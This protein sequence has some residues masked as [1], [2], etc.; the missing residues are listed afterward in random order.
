MKRIMVGFLIICFGL[1]ASGK[2]K[3][4][5]Y[6]ENGVTVVENE[7][8]GIWSEG[9]IEFRET[10]SI[11]KEEGED[12][13]ILNGQYLDAVAAPDGSIYIF[14]GKNYRLLKFDKHGKFLWQVGRRG[15]GPGEFRNIYCDIYVLPDG[16][17]LVVDEVF[18]NF[19]SPD[20]KYRRT[21]KL[22]RMPL[23]VEFIGKEKMFVQVFVT[24][25][26]G[27]AGAFYSLDGK[28]IS[29]LPVEY[30]Y[31]PK[32][33]PNVGASIGGGSLR[34]YGKKVFMSLPD[35]YEIREYTLDGKLLRV[36][37]RKFRINPP[38]IKVIFGGRGVRVYPSDSSGPA[39]L[40]MNRYIVNMVRKV[41]KKGKKYDI[42]R[43]LDFF[44]LKGQ[45]LGSYRLPEDTE[46]C[47][48]DAEGN[49]YFV[50]SDPVPRVYR[51]KLIVH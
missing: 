46:F 51:A 39:W 33:S 23:Y 28:L 29:R 40:Y 21:L 9:A 18:L 49:F 30:R 43:Y 37:R 47:Y 8:E 3:G 1:T 25:Q 12:Y 35:K 19:F 24:G 32:L 15:E 44:N 31:G 14:D 5:V 11:G 38:N 26:P 27:I 41:S 16:G 36:I 4:R 45:Y 42:K 48:I 2:W 50:Q 13:Y 6:T 10:L 20:G 34:I 7:G 17:V 22:D